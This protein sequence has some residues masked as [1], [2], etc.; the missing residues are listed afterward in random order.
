MQTAAVLV[1]DGLLSAVSPCCMQAIVLQGIVGCFPWQAMV[2]FTLW[3]QLNGFSNATS[4]FLVAT[5]GAGV[6]LVRDTAQAPCACVPPP[7]V[8][9]T[10]CRPLVRTETQQ[11]CSPV[12]L[13]CLCPQLLTHTGPFVHAAVSARAGVCSLLLLR[14]HW[15]A[16]ASATA[17]LAGC[18]TTDESSRH[19]SVCFVASRSLG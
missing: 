7:E 6:A 9:V 1:P 17:W 2:F 14:V 18:P 4:S 15:W 11:A 5:F 8:P 10:L 13:H 16:A 19:R 3:L 12:A